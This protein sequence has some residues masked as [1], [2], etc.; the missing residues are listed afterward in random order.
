MVWGTEGGRRRWAQSHAD[1]PGRRQP[2]GWVVLVAL[3]FAIIL[4]M[5]LHRIRD[6]VRQESP[7][8]VSPPPVQPVPAPARGAPEGPTVPR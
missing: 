2:L 4:V 1:A 5:S 8:S 7:G 6:H 3:I